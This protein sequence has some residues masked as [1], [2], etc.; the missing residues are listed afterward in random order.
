MV[1]APQSP[2]PRGPA[3]AERAERAGRAGRAGV[4]QRW[5]MLGDEI[6]GGATVEQGE[7][8]AIIVVG[9]ELLSGALRESN[10]HF[11]SSSLRSHGIAVKQVLLI[12]SDIDV[13]AFL[14]RRLSPV[15]RHVFVAGGV[16]PAHTDVTLAAVSKAFGVGMT[17][18]AGLLRLVSDCT[19][20]HHFSEHHLR[21]AYV[22]YG[23]ELVGKELP[24][25]GEVGDWSALTARWP[26]VKKNNVYV[27]PTRW[28]HILRKRFSE[29]LPLLQSAFE[30]FAST[31]ITFRASVEKAQVAASIVEALKAHPKVASHTFAESV[32]GETRTVLYLES[33]DPAQ[34]TG[35]SDMVLGLIAPEWVQAVRPP[36]APPRAPVPPRRACARA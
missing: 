35:A 22:P 9:D 15:H 36:P 34:Q 12:E 25:P 19:P 3:A 8:A 16:G 32:G 2:R 29:L 11:I 18:H 4:N 31:R 23:A 6:A 14:L 26:S 13:I 27:L 7:T 1:P 17:E 33:K 30:P 24:V 10:S 21:M 28:P 20:R 5:T